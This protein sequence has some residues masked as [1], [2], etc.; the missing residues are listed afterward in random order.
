MNLLILADDLTGAADSAARCHHAGLDAHVYL[1]PPSRA[2]PEGAA[3]FST[4][5]RYLSPVEAATQV[6][7]LLQALP[8]SE[9]AQ[10]YKKIDSTL[11]GNIG[12]EL[13]ALLAALPTQNAQPCAVICPAFPA[14]GRGLENGYLVYAQAPQPPLHLPTLLATQTERMVTAIV[15]DDVR[16]D[17]AHLAEKMAV[18]VEQG[19][20]LLVV[21]AL[22]EAD[23]DQL[24]AAT[25]QA[26]PHALL[27][28]SAGL[29]EPLAR[30]RAKNL[31][32]TLPVYAETGEIRSPMLAVIG[33]GSRMAHRQLAKLRAC[34]QV[35]CGELAPG[36]PLPNLASDL[37]NPSRAWALHLP[38]P[39]EQVLLEGAT[40]RQFVAQLTDA[41]VAWIQRLQ[42]QT[43]LIVGGDTAVHLLEAL[44]IEQLTIVAELM[45][46][47]PLSVGQDK[48]GQLWRIITKAGNFGDE[49]TLVRL[50]QRAKL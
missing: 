31:P 32:R 34:S 5:S 38:E 25:H 9:E 4:D 41:A 45:P 19:A 42:P 18:A 17:V 35:I 1:S 6:R 20:Q 36:S 26:L 3:A 37:V 16:R 14:Q 39:G 46:G 48:T 44:G 33:S 13:D 49:A 28:G 40:A 24:L 23:L 50:F 22:T 11:R 12:A 2:L 30:E 29:I 21:D 27:C 43:L 47:I 7:N 8:V 15:L 10:W